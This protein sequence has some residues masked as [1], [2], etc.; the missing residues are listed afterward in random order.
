MSDLNRHVIRRRA[1]DAK[2]GP[3]ACVCADIHGVA[4]A[5]HYAV[6]A[7]MTGIRKEKDFFVTE[8]WEE[9]ASWLSACVG[10]PD[11]TKEVLLECL[12]EVRLAK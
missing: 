9:A 2:A 11:V 4:A 8:D 12:D 3:C 5:R 7:E 1:M 6:L 10:A